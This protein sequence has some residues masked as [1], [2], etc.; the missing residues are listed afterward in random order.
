MSFQRNCKNCEFNFDGIC[1][2]GGDI[3]K[4]GEK[5]TD[6]RKLCD[7]WDA[8]LDAFT[9]VINEAPRFL[10]ELHNDCHISFAKLLEL[11]EA[12][13]KCN[14]VAINFFDAIKAVYGISM[15]DIAVLMDVSFGVVYNAKT[16]GFPPKRVRQFTTT[17][18]VPEKF[19]RNVTTADFDELSECRKEFYSNPS[20]ESRLDAMPEWKSELASIISSHYLHCPIHIA[21]KIARVD[22]MHWAPKV[23][24]D[25]Y[26][27]SER[28]LIDYM[29]RK[30][31]KGNPDV[32]KI[33]YFLDIGCKPH[34]HTA[35]KN[36]EVSH[37]I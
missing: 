14:G 3:Y 23:N 32:L 31:K 35:L 24:I 16:K 36:S 27:E 18:C 30:N 4:Y 15:V 22:K 25:E 28:M 34:L 9:E 33:E 13:S 29:N 6:D 7:S 2:G 19:L 8:N 11:V 21:K 26:T 10:R 1:A 17:L 37:E 12:G 5:I 20:L